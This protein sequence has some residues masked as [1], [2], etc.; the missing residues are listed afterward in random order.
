MRGNGL[1]SNLGRN[2]NESL[3]TRTKNGI[4]NTIVMAL[5][6]I[7]VIILAI[8]LVSGFVRSFLA[9]RPHSKDLPGNTPRQSEF[10]SEELYKL[11]ELKNRGILTEEEYQ[12][13]K[14]KLLK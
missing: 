11:H 10:I 1:F 4:N 5:V 6:K 2:K 13:Q 9:K 8:T 3:G 7:I 12:R 14:N